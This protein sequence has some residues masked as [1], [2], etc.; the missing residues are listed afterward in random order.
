MTWKSPFYEKK[1]EKALL[2]KKKGSI[3]YSWD[4]VCSTTSELGP[5]SG[6]GFNCE[7][8]PLEVISSHLAFSSCHSGLQAVLFN[9]AKGEWKGLPSSQLSTFYY[10]IPCLLLRRS[11]GFKSESMRLGLS[12]SSAMHSSVG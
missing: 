4:C 11:V 2:K 10:P 7:S 1:K 9:V 5:E 6:P 8:Y 12:L 3:K